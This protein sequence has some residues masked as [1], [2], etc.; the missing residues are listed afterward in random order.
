MSRPAA[1]QPSPGNT[2]PAGL[3]QREGQYQ[4]IFEGS[5]DGLYLWD[6]QLRIVDVNPA[7]LAL[8]GYTRDDL[9]GHTYPPSMPDAHVRDRIDMIRRAL[10]GHTTHVETTV[11]R[12]NGTSF[13]ADLRV[14][15]FL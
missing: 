7:G 4:A 11:L 10:A 12:P 13:E 5:Q 15:P 6:E 9:I 2:V 14:M 8:Y 3:R 1:P